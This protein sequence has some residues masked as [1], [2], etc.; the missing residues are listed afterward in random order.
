VLEIDL[1]EI[2]PHWLF[3]LQRRGVTAPPLPP[4]N[5][6]V[7]KAKGRP[8][9]STARTITTGRVPREARD[10]SQFKIARATQCV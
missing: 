3:W 6:V 9:G 2:N 10:S 7:V 4:I 8:K 1:A 5:P